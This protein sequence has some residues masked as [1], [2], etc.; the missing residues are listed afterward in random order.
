MGPVERREDEL[1]RLE[2]TDQGA[3]WVAAAEAL[4]SAAS[5]LADVRRTMDPESVWGRLAVGRERTVGWY[6][7]LH[8][9]LAEVGFQ[10]P[11]L[12]EL[13]SILAEL[14]RPAS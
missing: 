9:R 8:N 10:A 13:A 1:V 4:H 5:L 6:R 3:H 14:E 12:A 7:R 11:I 2:A